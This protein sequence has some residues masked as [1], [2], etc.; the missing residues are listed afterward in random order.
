MPTSDS[1]RYRLVMWL[2]S[3]TNPLQVALARYYDD[4]KQSETTWTPEPFDSWDDIR[5][6]AQQC[7]TTAGLQEVLPFT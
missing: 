4:V 2:D 6:E 1:H 3:A 7:I 5:L